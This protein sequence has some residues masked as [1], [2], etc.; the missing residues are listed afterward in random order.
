MLSPALIAELQKL[1]HGE[2]IK[3]LAELRHA[4]LWLEHHIGAECERRGCV[5]CNECGKHAPEQ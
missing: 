4:A 3:R 1:S 2:K 5:D